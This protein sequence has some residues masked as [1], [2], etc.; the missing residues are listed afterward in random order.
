VKAPVAPALH[1]A[2]L[3]AVVAA[4]STRDPRPPEW[5]L[6]ALADLVAKLASETLPREADSTVVSQVVKLAAELVSGAY[7]DASP[8]WRDPPEDGWPR[9][10]GRRNRLGAIAGAL[11]QSAALSTPSLDALPSKLRHRAL[12][13]SRTAVVLLAR[14]DPAVGSRLLAP[15]RARLVLERATSAARSA[16]DMGAKA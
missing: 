10:A 8:K 16:H 4:T 14:S 9:G 1:A 15:E 3:G 12:H 5:T 11:A 13:L 6:L 2:S 7:L